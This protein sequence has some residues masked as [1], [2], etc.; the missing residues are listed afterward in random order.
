MNPEVLLLILRVLLALV[1]YAFFGFAI[2]VVWRSVS[3]RKNVKHELPLTYAVEYQDERLVR[4][5]R[6]RAVNLIGRA[7]DNTIVL[8]DERTSAHHARI[9]FTGGQWVLE[10]LGSRNGTFVNELRVEGQIVIT[11]EDRV[12]VGASILEITSETP[13]GETTFTL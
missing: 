13:Q 11:Y 12:Q 2:A 7:A 5:H 10:D 3:G 6:L 4:S 8:S 9:T 1:L